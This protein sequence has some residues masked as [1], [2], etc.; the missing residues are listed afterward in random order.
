[1]QWY[2]YRL[3]IRWLCTSISKCLWGI[4]VV[5]ASPSSP[6]GNTCLQDVADSCRTGSAT[7]IIFGLALGYKSCIIPTI[8]IAIAIFTGNSLAGMYGVATAALGMLGTL[9]TGGCCQVGMARC[10]A[11]LALSCHS[12]QNDPSGMQWLSQGR[13]CFHSFCGN[14]V[15]ACGAFAVGELNKAVCGDSR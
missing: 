8:C 13:G 2:I 6:S 14:F 7:N 15:G 4:Y 3:Q 5:L 12:S 11:H 9:A 1:M 10:Q